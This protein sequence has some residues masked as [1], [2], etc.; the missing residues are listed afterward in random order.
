MTDRNLF[1]FD[2]IDGHMHFV[3]IERFKYYWM[4]EVPE[5]LRHSFDPQTANI[6][7]SIS[8][9]A[10]AIVVQAHPSISETLHLVELAEQF[11]FVRGIV[12]T[13]DLL[14]QGIDS[15]IRDYQKHTK[16]RAVR[17]QQA[18]DGDFDWFLQ[19]R[20]LSNLKILAQSGLPYDFLCR[21]HQLNTLSKVAIEVPMLRIILEHAG[22]PEI[23]LGKFDDWA[24]AIEP[25]RD[26]P[27]VCCKVSEL[28]PQAEGTA[29]S[30]SVLRPYISHIV[31]VFGY[32]R[33]IWGSGWPICLLASDYER[34]ISA[35]LENVESA[36]EN[37][38]RL[39]FRENAIRWYRLTVPDTG[40]K[41]SES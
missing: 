11:P 35:I 38:L 6:E 20:V 3:N 16:I 27:N 23:K 29:W 8:G 17:H 15:T 12:A 41:D 24:A 36:T 21:P 4:R 25:L 31:S 18:E 30:S 14:D 37:D 19:D 1:G 5:K 39:M 26:T 9:I 40:S 13:I 32:D 2:V 28:L 34:T 22:K 7:M 10:H 33:I